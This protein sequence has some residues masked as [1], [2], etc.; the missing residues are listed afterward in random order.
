M[1]SIIKTPEL[2]RRAVLAGVAGLAL[3]SMVPTFAF[4]V[5]EKAA[6]SFIQKVVADVHRIINTGKAE[7]QMLVDFEAIFRDYGEVPLIAKTV[8]GAPG[9]TASSSELSAYIRAFQGYLS[10]KY[11]RQFRDFAGAEINVVKS[12]DAGTKGVLVTSM[13]DRPNKPPFELEWWVI[14]INNGIKMFDLKIE[15]ISLISTERTEIGA[16]LESFGGDMG[17][18]TAH[19]NAN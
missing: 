19:L 10:R 6:V 1:R 9:R 13:V 14:D 16:L 11:G 5:T 3:S 12:R 15:G 7:P 2:P 18:M 8:L 17:K 4:G